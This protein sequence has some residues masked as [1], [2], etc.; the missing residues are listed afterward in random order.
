MTDFTDAQQAK[1][2]HAHEQIRMTFLMTQIFAERLTY[3]T[4][5]LTGKTKLRMPSIKD[6]AR[7]YVKLYNECELAIDEMDEELE[8][9]QDAL[10]AE[11]EALEAEQKESENDISV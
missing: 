10:E 7:R 6:M 4:L 1:H 2:A 5:N 3:K 8:E 9:L 11:Q